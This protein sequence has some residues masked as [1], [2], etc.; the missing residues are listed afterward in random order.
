MSFRTRDLANVDFSEID[1]LIAKL[2]PEEIEL[3]ENDVDPDVSTSSIDHNKF[4]FFLT[5]PSI[6]WSF[7]AWIKV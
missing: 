1:E 7:V 5:I 6:F 3:L 2:T 4:H